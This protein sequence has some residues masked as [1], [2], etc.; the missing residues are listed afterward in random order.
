MAL[1]AGH[2]RGVIARCDVEDLGAVA[3]G[4]HWGGRIDPREKRGSDDHFHTGNRRLMTWRKQCRLS[5]G[6]SHK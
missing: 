6:Q 2:H 5:L 1:C 4:R 3:P